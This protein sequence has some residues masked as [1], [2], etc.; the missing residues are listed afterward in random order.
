MFLPVR[1]A[2]G[3][4]LLLG[5][6]PDK[7]AGGAVAV[8]DD[9]RRNRQLPLKLYLDGSLTDGVVMTLGSVVAD[10]SVWSELEPAWDEVLRKHGVRYSHM[11]ELTGGIEQF[12]DWTRKQRVA[13]L[14]DLVGVL[15]RYG[16]SDR[17]R[18]YACWVDLRAHGKWKRIRNH[19]SP[20][21]LCARVLFPTF[22]KDYPGIIDTIDVWFD[23]N[24]RF[25]THLRE[26]WDNPKIRKRSPVWGLVR[27]IGLADMTKYRRYNWPI[28]SRGL[29]IVTRRR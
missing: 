9:P 17:I 25:M 2:L 27:T 7:L 20:E 19:P 14:G 26:N 10:E 28:S 1:V 22:I 24:E 4:A 13:F 11:K 21:R 6:I 15:E 8:I 5:W 18:Q 3:M 23:Q 29:E 16:P 12:T